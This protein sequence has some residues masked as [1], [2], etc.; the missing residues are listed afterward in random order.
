MREVRDYWP[1]KNEEAH[2]LTSTQRVVNIYS[3]K[4]TRAM[5]AKVFVLRYIRINKY[6]EIQ[7]G[8]PTE[9]I[10]YVATVV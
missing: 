9:V 5:L 2:A 7:G 1:I 10:E 3:P 8:G 4:Q 6:H